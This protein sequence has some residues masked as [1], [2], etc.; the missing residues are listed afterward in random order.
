[1]REL[2][3]DVSYITCPSKHKHLYCPYDKPGAILID[4]QEALRQQWQDAGGI[5]IQHT[6]TDDT[7]RQL[8]SLLG[9][10]LEA[11]SIQ[12]LC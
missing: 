6:T 4:D 7:I 12:H 8:E 2:G 1:M 11:S 3:P 9:I 5:F 10:H